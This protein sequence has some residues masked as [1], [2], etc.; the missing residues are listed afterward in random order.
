MLTNIHNAPAEGNLCS[1]GGKAIKSQIFMDYNHHMGYV[2][3]GDRTANRYSD[4]SR[5]FKWTKKLFF[6][7][8][9]PAN[10]NSYILH[11][12]CGGMKISHR[13][14]QYT[15]ARNMLVHAGPEWTVQ[16]PLGRPPNVE[17][18]VARLEVY[19]RKRWPIPSETQPRYR[20]CKDTGVTKIKCL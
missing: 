16:R 3:K 17:S 8:L 19:C 12:S 6:H 10:L 13:D 18:H 1:E 4:S 5:R 11:S 2:Y 15:L 14:F 9:D 20:T 7:L